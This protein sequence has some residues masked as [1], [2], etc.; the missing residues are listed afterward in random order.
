MNPV[1]ALMIGAGLGA[2]GGVVLARAR[3]CGSG[4]CH[5]RAN[6]IASIVAGA[7]FGAAVAWYALGRD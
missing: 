6:F 5:V 7:F 1:A 2:A 4:A 3:T